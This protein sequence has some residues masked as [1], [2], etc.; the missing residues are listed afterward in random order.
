[1]CGKVSLHVEK[2]I[3]GFLENS[4]AEVIYEPGC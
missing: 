1:M 3:K 4:G 2:K